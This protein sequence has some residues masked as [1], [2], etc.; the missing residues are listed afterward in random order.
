[1]AVGF[2][3]ANSQAVAT[4]LDP[5]EIILMIW[6]QSHYLILKCCDIETVETS[7]M[8]RQDRCLFL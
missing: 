2:T 3:A 4:I 8:L 5:I 1:M 6:G 7:D